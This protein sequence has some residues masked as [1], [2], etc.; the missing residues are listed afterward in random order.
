M[1]GKFP[2][3]FVT[4]QWADSGEQHLKRY[5]TYS[6]QVAG[7]GDSG[8][9]VLDR[10]GNVHLVHVSS[11]NTKSN[12]FFEDVHGP[13]RHRYTGTVEADDFAL[14]D[15]QQR[16]LVDGHGMG[17]GDLQ[18]RANLTM[19]LRSQSARMHEFIYHSAM[20]S[21]MEGSC[22]GVSIAALH[23][24]FASLEAKQASLLALSESAQCPI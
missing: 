10:A 6:P 11:G 8:A 24:L 17:A 14:E 22:R 21:K 1:W 3:K 2:P 15:L 13:N 4:P 16:H 18:G 5:A 7:P 23:Q 20:D 19:Y 9:P 12:T